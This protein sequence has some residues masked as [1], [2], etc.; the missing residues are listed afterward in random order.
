MYEGKELKIT[1]EEQEKCS[2]IINFYVTVVGG[3]GKKNRF[4]SKEIDSVTELI[5]ISMI[6]ELGDVFQH[7]LCDDVAKVILFECNETILEKKRMGRKRGK[8]ISVYGNEVD[9]ST[10][11]GITFAIGWI[12][13]CDLANKE[14]VNGVANFA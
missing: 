2:K 14:S 9:I 5:Y 13:T 10:S 7:K 12:A 4:T 8:V 11:L 1:K 3:F 6:K